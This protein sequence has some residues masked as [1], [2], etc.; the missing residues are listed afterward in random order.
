MDAL[1]PVRNEGSMAHPTEELLEKAEATLV[2]DMSRTMLRYIDTKISDA[3]PGAEA[4]TGGA[5]A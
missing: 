2:I 5:K 3:E 4:D 1:N